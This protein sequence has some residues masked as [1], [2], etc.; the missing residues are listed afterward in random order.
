MPDPT[1]DDEVEKEL[2]RLN[3]FPDS[4]WPEKDKRAPVVTYLGEM[5]RIKRERGERVGGHTYR[6]QIAKYGIA[7]MFAE[8]ASIT[9]RLE[10]L[11]WKNQSKKVWLDW[12]ALERLQDLCIDMGNYS[13]FIW[14][15][16]AEQMRKQ[17]V[18]DFQDAMDE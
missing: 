1:T 16:A 3:G 6:D 18:N 4:T 17:E 5:A 7:V 9:S 12:P 8:I 11:L 2:K 13:S 15:W 14:E 10:M